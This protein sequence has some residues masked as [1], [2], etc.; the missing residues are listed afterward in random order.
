MKRADVKR[1]VK[2]ELKMLRAMRPA[3]M[4]EREE[5]RAVKVVADE[6]RAMGPERPDTSAAERQRSGG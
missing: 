1:R 3:R 4:V 5:D 2:V 6:A